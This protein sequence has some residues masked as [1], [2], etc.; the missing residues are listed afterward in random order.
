M[1]ST[2]AGKLNVAGQGSAAARSRQLETEWLAGTVVTASLALMAAGSVFFI[3]KLGPVA[4]WTAITTAL[5]AAIAK[6]AFR[7]PKPDTL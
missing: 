7:K 3:P 1:R 4:G 6:L 2:T 5:L